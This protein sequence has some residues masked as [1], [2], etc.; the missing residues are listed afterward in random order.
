[1]FLKSRWAMRPSI[2]C[3]CAEVG[4]DKSGLSGLRKETTTVIFVIV[5]GPK[6]TGN[7]VEESFYSWQ[8]DEACSSREV[9]LAF[10]TTNDISVR[11]GWYQSSTVEA[12]SKLS[13]RA[14]TISCS[15]RLRPVHRR[16][17]TRCWC[18]PRRHSSCLHHTE[19]LYRR[20]PRYLVRSSGISAQGRPQNRGFVWV[21]REGRSV[22]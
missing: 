18:F 10:D 19:S 15:L 1:M 22:A 12:G 13:Q 7:M 9:M 21:I 16:R 17:V 11:V 2:L 14:T 4:F 8:H 20:R 3:L 5:S 6:R